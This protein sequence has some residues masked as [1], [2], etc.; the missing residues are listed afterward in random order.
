MKGSHSNDSQEKKVMET[1]SDDRLCQAGM[2]NL[3][4]EHDFVSPLI[5][6]SK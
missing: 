4:P 1:F 5:I 6:K 3:P 2:R